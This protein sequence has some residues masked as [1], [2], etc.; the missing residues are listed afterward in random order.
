MWKNWNHQNHPSEPQYSKYKIFE[1]HPGND[2]KTKHDFKFV[3]S[4]GASSNDRYIIICNKWS[5]YIVLIEGN[6]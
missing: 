2:V 4:T 3:K 1:E 6:K 5:N